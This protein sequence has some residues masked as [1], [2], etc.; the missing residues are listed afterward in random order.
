LLEV[1]HAN[2][3]EALAWSLKYGDVESGLQIAIS[4]N[5]FWQKRGYIQEAFEWFER[6]LAAVEGKTSPVIQATAFSTAAHIA[7]LLGNAS[8]TIEYGRKAGALGQ[9]TGK[10][11]QSNMALALVG[12]ASSVRAAGDYQTAFTIGEESIQL[13]VAQVICISWAV[14]DYA[15]WNRDAARQV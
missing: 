14:S 13:L 1:E 2:F 12:L 15:G 4:L 5:E 3:R 10:E 6:L 9:V 11:E 7:M 8:A